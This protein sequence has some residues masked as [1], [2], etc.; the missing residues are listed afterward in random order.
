MP[1]SQDPI[2]GLY[3]GYFSSEDGWA[4][5]MDYNLLKIGALAN[6]SVISRSLTVPPGSPV[7]GARYIPA[8][9][10]SGLWSGKDLKIAIW[11]TDET[12]WEFYNPIEGMLCVVTS[13][14]TW[15]TQTVFKGG[16]WS[17]GVALG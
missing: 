4:E 16:A 14:G 1:A 12:A 10:A 11:R 5:Q 6:L 13:E 7:N 9:G 15:G 8:P 3:Y 17:P 2:M